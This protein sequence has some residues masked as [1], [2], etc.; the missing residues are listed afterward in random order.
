MP[1]FQSAHDSHFSPVSVFYRLI[2]VS[3]ETK[4]VLYQ[5]NNANK[6][7][8]TITQD[9]FFKVCVCV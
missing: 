2:D 4:P 5:D 7:M 8:N 3:Y 1:V 9:A 6:K